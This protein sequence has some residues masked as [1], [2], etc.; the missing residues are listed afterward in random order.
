MGCEA[1]SADLSLVTKLMLALAEIDSGCVVS[2]DKHLLESETEEIVGGF[3][4]VLPVLSDEL[5]GGLRED[6]INFLKSLVLGLRH[7]EELV[8]PSVETISMISR[9]LKYEHHSFGRHVQVLASAEA[10]PKRRCEAS[11]RRNADFSCD[12]R[13]L[14][15]LPNKCDA[16]IEPSSQTNVGERFGHCGEVV[17]DDEG[18]EEQPAV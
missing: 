2:I 5:A 8:E 3:L 14:F 9:S 18:G 15:N 6:E 17:R 7:E 16:A 13:N 1:R 10:S 4:D 12:F 11:Y